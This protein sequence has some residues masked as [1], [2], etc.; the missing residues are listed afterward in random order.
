LKTGVDKNIS[1]WKNFCCYVFPVSHS[2]KSY[3]T[4]K[5]RIPH[6]L[7][8]FFSLLS[9]SDDREFPGDFLSDTSE[10]FEED[11]ASFEVGESTDK[12]KSYK[13]SGIWHLFTWNKIDS[14][15]NDRNLIFTSKRLDKCLAC[16]TNSYYFISKSDDAPSEGIVP[17]TRKCDYGPSI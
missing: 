15:E 12:G 4:S 11:M 14:S 3:S 1:I 6:L 2:D 17:H 8:E 13:F 16:F 7:F 9:I 10:G 5:I